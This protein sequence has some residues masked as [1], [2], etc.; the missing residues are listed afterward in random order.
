MPTTVTAVPPADSIRAADHFESFLT[1]ETD[2]WDVRQAMSSG[3]P[4]FVLLDVRSA[5]SYRKGHVEGAACLP[6]AGI[7]EKTLA[8]YSSDTVFVVYCSGP[9]CNG[10]HRAAIRLARL[11]RPVKM[12]IG[13]ITGW[14]GEGFELVS[15]AR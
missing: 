15:G 3:A 11:G 1:F 4:D 8:G 12:M 14:I 6:H 9:H 5:D 7:S 10:A 13:G 2:C